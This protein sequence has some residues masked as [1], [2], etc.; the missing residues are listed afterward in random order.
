M[1]SKP[2]N[3]VTTDFS[4]PISPPTSNRDRVSSACEPYRE[5]IEQGLRRGRN[6]MAIWQDLVSEHGFPR[7]YETVKRFVRK[8][9]GA[10]LPQAV[11]IILT[12]AGPRSWT[13][14]GAHRE[15]A[16]V[17]KPSS[18]SGVDAFAHGA[19]GRADWTEHRSTIREDP[20]REAAS[21]D[22]LS[23]VSGYHPTRRAVLSGQDGS[24]ADRALLTGACRYQSVKSILKNSL[25]Q[26]PL[27]TSPALPPPPAH[28]NVRGA[29][30]CYLCLRYVVSAMSPGR[31]KIK[32]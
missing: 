30:K 14:S 6:A 13:R 12:A 7:G 26:Q 1:E 24:G 29:E 9:R 27:S 11:G 3:A 23:I 10:E 17:E 5:L 16:P 15:R 18:A 22:G 20:C 21:G 31:T 32:W 8:L 28:D 25:D 19:L 2:A 4:P